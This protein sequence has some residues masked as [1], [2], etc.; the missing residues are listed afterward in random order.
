MEQVLRAQAEAGEFGNVDVEAEVARRMG[1]LRSGGLLGTLE[2]VRPDGRVVELH[3]NAVAGGG[4]VTLITDI[5]ARK[6]AENELRHARAEAE[7]ATASKMRFAAMVSH[8]IRTPLHALLNSLDLLAEPG[9]QAARSAALDAAQRSGDALLGLVDDILDLSKIETGQLALRP[10]RFQL[11]PLLESALTMLRPRAE[12]RGSRLRLAIADDAPEVL[13]ADAGRLRQ[14]IVNLLA[15]AVQYA[16]P[17]E[18]VLHA[19]RESG[20]AVRTM[21]LSVSDPGPP[22]PP[23]QRER[24]FEPFA[25]FSMTNVT[26]LRAVTSPAVIPAKAGIHA[27]ARELPNR[28]SACRR[29]SPANGARLRTIG[30]RRTREAV[31]VLPSVAG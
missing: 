10:N 15:N 31:L 27:A 18:V 17:G 5:T 26:T 16:D 7:A 19:S 30:L 20:G 23:A 14:V 25:Q 1:L 3:R 11:R 22:I 6:L 2:R 8:E 29:L 28:L 4:F 12:L 21:R 9:M 24:L 13:I